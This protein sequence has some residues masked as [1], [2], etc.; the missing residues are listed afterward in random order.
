MR[1]ALL[2]VTATAL[3]IQPAAG[4]PAAAASITQAV[5]SIADLE[6]RIADDPNDHE[7]RTRLAARV[8]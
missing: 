6:L 5:D 1:S 4:G 2:V 3:L 8:D 7:A